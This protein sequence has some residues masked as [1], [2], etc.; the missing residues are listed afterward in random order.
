[1]V[2]LQ[3]MAEYTFNNVIRQTHCK[4]MAYLPFQKFVF[5]FFFNFISSNL[6]LF[7]FKF[8]FKNDLHDLKSVYDLNYWHACCSDTLRLCKIGIQKIEKNPITSLLFCGISSL[9]WLIPDFLHA[10]FVE[11][12]SFSSTLYYSNL[13]WSQR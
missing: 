12:Y 6:I 7:K 13:S 2:T 1:M 8:Y 3:G 9:E 11:E 5:T 10:I 4:R